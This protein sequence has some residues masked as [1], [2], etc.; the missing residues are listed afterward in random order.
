VR[1]SRRVLQAFALVL[2]LALALIASVGALLQLQGGMEPFRVPRG[3]TT[4]TTSPAQIEHGRYLAAIGNCIGCHTLPEGAPLAGG[5]PFRTPYG[6]VYS[7]N[8]TPDVERGIGRWS[9][10]EFRH[11]MRHGVSRN[12]VLSPVFP[13]ASFRH[14]GDDDLD[15]LL[16]YLLAQTPAAAPRRPAQYTWPANLPGAMLGW[17]MLH[18]RPVPLAP[19]ASDAERRGVYLVEGIGH[20]GTCHR[21]RGALA[22]QAAGPPLWGARNAG[23]Y[24]PAL[25]AASMARFGDGEVARYLRGDAPRGI[26]AY[27]LM[28]D[29]VAG[30]LQHL[31]ADDADAIEAHLR[32][33]PAPPT[34]RA[35]PAASRVGDASLALG[36]EVYGRH[37]ADCHGERG[38]GEPDAS[39]TLIASAA[40]VAPDPLN[41]I[42]LVMFGAVAPSTPR[43]PMPYTMPPFAQQLGATEIAAVVNLLRV[44]ENP[45]ASPVSEAEVRALG[46][47]E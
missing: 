9:S 44:Q 30:N 8:I 16:A 23:W 46:G 15:A 17:R 6:T 7:S 35:L 21:S 5:V 33:L 42:K 4:P 34:R 43:N 18:Y 31:T 22:S 45:Q 13:Y 27:G 10:E 39:P 47:I 14:L 36:R 32:S 38:E 11:A 12:G 2:P 20:C 19:A 26:G 3:G 28:A 41:L 1:R 24:A 25:H 40:V 29:V 37:C